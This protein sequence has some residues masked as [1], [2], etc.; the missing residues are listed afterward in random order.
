MEC[1]PI[2]PPR[3]R[4]FLLGHGGPSWGA[5]GARPRGYSFGVRYNFVE[6]LGLGTF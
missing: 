5:G 3:D 1:P 6:R 4:P 2:I